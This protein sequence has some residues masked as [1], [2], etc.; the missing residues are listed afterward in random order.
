MHQQ[1][2]AEEGNSASNNH[3]GNSERL[4]LVFVVLNFHFQMLWNWNLHGY[5]LW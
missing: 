1:N 3:S 4:L 2:S 5:D